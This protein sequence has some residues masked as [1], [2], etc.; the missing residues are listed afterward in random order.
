MEVIFID[1]AFVDSINHHSKL[2]D[3]VNMKPTHKIYIY[4]CVNIK[5]GN[6]AQIYFV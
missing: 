1:F 3:P 5:V 2:A 6:G 4:M